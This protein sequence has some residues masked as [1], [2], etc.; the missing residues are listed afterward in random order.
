MLVG[1][2]VAA[3]CGFLYAIRKAIP[4]LLKGIFFG[5]VALALI[6]T[7]HFWAALCGLGFYWLVKDLVHPRIIVVQTPATKE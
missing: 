2:A 4:A 1:L 6:A 5:L 3:I 7:G